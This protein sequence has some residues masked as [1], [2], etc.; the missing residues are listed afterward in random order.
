M[1]LILLLLVVGVI[2]FLVNWITQTLITSPPVRQLVWLLTIIVLVF[3]VL[4]SFGVAL[5]NVIR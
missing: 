4:R 5:P 1:D 3:Y 2:C